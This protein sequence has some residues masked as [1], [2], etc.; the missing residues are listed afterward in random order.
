MQWLYLLVSG[1]ADAGEQSVDVYVNVSSRKLKLLF[2]MI[3]GLKTNN[4]VSEIMRSMEGNLAAPVL[5]Y[6][7][8]DCQLLTMISLSSFEQE[9]RSTSRVSVAPQILWVKQ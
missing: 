9:K 6:H 7:A 1:F 4:F 3:P 2:E 5:H 8:Y